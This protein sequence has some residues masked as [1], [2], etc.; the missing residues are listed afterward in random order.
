MQAA[1]WHFITGRGATA[2]H[3]R[4]VFLYA[5]N[6]FHTSRQ[7]SHAVAD[8]KLRTHAT[9]IAHL[10][11]LRYGVSDVH[12]T[13]VFAFFSYRE[14]EVEAYYEYR[15]VAPTALATAIHHTFSTQTSHLA[16]VARR[17]SALIHTAPTATHVPTNTPSPKPTLTPTATL[18]AAPSA[19]AVIVPPT[20]TVAPTPT[21]FP[22][23]T[24]PP[25]PTPSPTVA[26]SPTGLVVQAQPQN[27]TYAVRDNAT[28]LVHAT[29]NG[30]PAVGASVN[31]SVFFPGNP[32]NCG[33][34]IDAAGNASCSVVVPVERS[35]TAIQ[36]N[37]QVVSTTGEIATTNTS[38]T[39]R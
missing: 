14:V 22:I 4:T 2:W 6:L 9:R 12:E 28:V 25:P 11:A 30:Q 34:T 8:E 27:P 1:V 35:G 20:S 29:F 5:I 31:V 23:P 36:V 32:T 3:H 33:A 21:P 39:I 7:A 26:P 16:H 17:L 19:T 38:F 15:G 24:S 37:V 18:T 10:P 13:L